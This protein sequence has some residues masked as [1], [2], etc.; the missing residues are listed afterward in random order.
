M[1]HCSGSGP[2]DLRWFNRSKHKPAPR[3]ATPLLKS[4]PQDAANG[5]VVSGSIMHGQ[6]IRTRPSGLAQPP[7]TANCDTEI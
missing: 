2:L 3:K 5:P 4:T 6:T 1:A 7:A